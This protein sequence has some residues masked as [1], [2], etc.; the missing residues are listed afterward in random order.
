MK[1]IFE[2]EVLDIDEK[3]T[4]LSEHKG[5]AIVVVNVASFDKEYTDTNYKELERLYQK[6]KKEGLVILGFPCNQF[7]H[8]ERST[9]QQIKEFCKKKNVS[10]PVFARI[11]VNGSDQDELFKYLKSKKEGQTG[12]SSISWN[13]EKFFINRKGEVVERLHPTKGWDDVEKAIKKIL[14]K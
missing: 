13:F 12:F 5:K 1:D 11:E 2:I 8:S 3:K 4:T 10:F 6:F 9:N 14:E 7:H